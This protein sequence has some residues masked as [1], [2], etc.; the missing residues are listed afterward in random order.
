MT[1]NHG[2]LYINGAWVTS[3]GV[4]FTSE[5]PATGEIIWR[6]KAANEKD[7]DAAMKA[8][9]A[10]YT[11]WGFLPVEDRVAV[12]KAFS[13]VV[14]TRKS[15]LSTT[16]AQE[17]GKTLWDATSE[18]TAMIG[19]LN[20]SLAAYNERTGVKMGEG[21]GFKT[22]L[23]HKP[24]GVLAVYGPYNFPAHLPNGHIMPALIAGNTVVFKPSEFTPLVAE[25]VMEC[26]HEAKLPAGVINLVQGE[27]DT[28]KALA[29]HAE[30]DGL[31]FTGSSDTGAI[32]HKQFAG[33][34]HKILALELGGN[35]PLVVHEVTD[36]K[37]AAY[38]TIQ[39]AYVTSGQRCTCSRRLIVPKGN[40]AFITALVDMVKGIK[41][42]T[43]TDT[44]EPF[45]G[46]LISNKE[47]DKLLAAQA[48]FIKAGGK[49]LVEM[50]RLSAD[51]PFVSPALID[52]TNVKDRPDKEWFGPLLQLIR[53]KDMDAAIAEANKT[54]YG[55]SS[56]IFSDSRAHYEHFL[57]AV[58]AGVVNWNRPLTGSSGNLPFGGVGL[59][60]NHKPA[61]YY[62]ADYCAFPV[63]S[64]EAEKLVI[65]AA[66][67]PG[68]T[69]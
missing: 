11:T 59:S 22:A 26:W 69:L 16:L 23:R 53:V 57:S 48:E 35:N 46:C 43:Y 68:L 63:A 2:K 20:F 55:L 31:L 28:G 1:D 14:E 6:G 65:P 18:I 52:V 38:W 27:R 45:M 9:R 33:A 37:A 58:R 60:G 56:G 5:N 50:K 66:P 47:A 49:A 61:A 44:P 12:L 10:A 29:S 40:E 34:P 36:V 19:K 67:S 17:T 8:A 32:L 62:A 42:G 39:S 41:V 51:R 30:L 7:I 54:Q 24:H 13:A 21:Q 64:N 25:K 15:E 4:E 3:G